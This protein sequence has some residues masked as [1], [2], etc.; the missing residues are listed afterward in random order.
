MSKSSR[1]SVKVAVRLRPMSSKEKQQGFTNIV[2]INQ[3]QSSVY[4]TNNHGEKVQF[5]YDFAFPQNCTQEEIYESTSAPIVSGVLD[6]FNGTIF[7]YGQTGTGK[8]Y[9]M[10]GG[11]DDATKGITPRAFEHIFDYITTHSDSH[12]FSVTCTYVELYNEMIHDLLATETPKE[13]LTIHEENKTFYIKGVTTRSVN[14]IDDLFKLQA[15][16]R[17]R[18]K[19]RQTAMNDVSS[20]SHAIFS[21]SI[22][23]LA[24]I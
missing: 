24:D 14:T 16:G 1:E 9:T 19:T 11:S 17:K 4:I 12:R 18:R 23:T 10:D 5:T 6:G 13:P 20:R 7:A 8:T 22:E 15:Y 3:T 21:I 2:D